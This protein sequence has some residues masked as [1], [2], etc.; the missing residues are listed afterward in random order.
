MLLQRE[1]K[2][3]FR[4]DAEEVWIE[5]WGENA[6][7]V[8]ATKASIMPTEDWALQMPIFSASSDIL[9]EKLRGKI[10]NGN[11]KATISA[12]GKLMMFNQKGDIILEE[13]M[14]NRKDHMD[15]KASA[16]DVEARE[17][18]PLPGGD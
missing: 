13:Y 8:R 10:E 2:L 15:P 6:L 1:G 9:I 17:L 4:Y 7:R 18:K 11:L 14:R 12:M 16:L 5:P 3:I